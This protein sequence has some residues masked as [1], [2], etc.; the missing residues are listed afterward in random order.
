MEKEKVSKG[1]M[2]KEFNIL[3]V[4]ELA[5]VCSIQTWMPPAI[6]EC[7]PNDVC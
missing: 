7:V 5:D 2:M 6:D 3:R 1:G 4:I